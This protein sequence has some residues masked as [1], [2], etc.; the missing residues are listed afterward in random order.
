M[1]GPGGRVEMGGGKEEERGCVEAR[2][3]LE[4]WTRRGLEARGCLE[5]SC[6]EESRGGEL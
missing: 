4:V 1:D 3:C 2:G 6:Q 5:E